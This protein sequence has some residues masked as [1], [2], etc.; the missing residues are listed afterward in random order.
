MNAVRSHYPPDTHF[1]E[2][3]DSIGL[4]YL[5]ELCGWQNSYSTEIAEKLLPEMIFRDVNHPCIFVW[6]NGNEGGWNTAVDNRFADYDPQKRHVIHPWADFNGL[7]TRHYPNGTDNM[8]RLE[9]GHKVFMMT[10]F[11]HGLYDRGQGAGLKG[12]W[13]K[14]KANPLFCRWLPLGICG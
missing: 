9:R 7:D 13:S 10:E 12:L 4:L 11:L 1:L 14:F 8:Y 2:A 3:C 6:A 5:N